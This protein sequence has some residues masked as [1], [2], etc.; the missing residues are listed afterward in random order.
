MFIIYQAV[1]FLLF[2]GLLF[3]FMVGTMII[4]DHIALARMPG[5]WFYTLLFVS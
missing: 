5:G 4:N 3:P 2:L 1:L